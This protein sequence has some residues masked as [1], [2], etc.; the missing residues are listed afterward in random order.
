MEYI[1]SLFLLAQGNQHIV[2]LMAILAT[3]IESFIPALPLIGI[4]IMNGVLLGF[5]KGIIASVVGSCLGTL[6]L[7]LLS[8]KFS[9]LEYFNKF[10]NDKINKITEWIRNQSYIVLFLCY[11][12]TFVPSCLISISSGFSGKTLKS[13][14]PGMILG[15][16]S[17]FSVASYIGN[18]MQ[19]ILQKPQ[20]LI[21]IGLIVCISFIIGKKLTL[22]MENS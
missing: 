6:I 2:F 17:M 9:N 20:R 18:D 14:L 21:V 8:K 15:K 22:R 11:A 3:F 4:V 1:E 12:S 7:F 19:G 16:L 13:F 10:K 5:Y